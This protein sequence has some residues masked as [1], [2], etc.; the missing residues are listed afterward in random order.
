MTQFYSV[1]HNTI[2]TRGYPYI[3]SISKGLELVYYCQHEKRR[4][5]YA[6]GEVE[7]QLD[8]YKGTKW[9]DCLMSG[10]FPFFI[11]SERVIKCWEKERIG[12][13]PIN[14]VILTKPLPKQLR[15][16]APPRY[17]WIDG[18][19][20]NG[21]QMDFEASGFVGVRFCPECGTRSDNITETAKRQMAQD[22]KSAYVFRENTWN[23]LHLFTSDISETSFFCTETIVECARKYNLTNFRFIPIEEGLGITSK[24]LKYL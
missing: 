16:A 3:A 4:L 20:L 11:V 7:A 18:Q 2:Y 24:G 10:A 9:P 15:E 21:V 12:T 13:F 6:S 14:E 1:S 23:G 19:K 17:F 8:R 22:I 5:H